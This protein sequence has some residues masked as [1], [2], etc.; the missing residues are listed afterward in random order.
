MRQIKRS[1]VLTKDKP[2]WQSVWLAHTWIF[3]GHLTSFSDGTHWDVSAGW[4]EGA[5]NGSPV[6]RYDSTRPTW[7]E[8]INLTRFTVKSTVSTSLK[9]KHIGSNSPHYAR[10]GC[11]WTVDRRRD[12][13]SFRCLQ[14]VPFS[15]EHTRQGPIWS[16][17]YNPK[18]FSQKNALRVIVMQI[19][20]MSED[21]PNSSRSARKVCHPL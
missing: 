14:L 19:S 1:L 12:S 6:I 5:I 10:D 11:N 9:S 8:W 2:F 13:L 3:M 21:S 16:H 18:S 15:A 17:F 7:T 20:W 4:L